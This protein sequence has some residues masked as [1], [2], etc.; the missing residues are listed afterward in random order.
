MSSFSGVCTFP[1]FWQHALHNLKE[2]SRS[3][4]FILDINAMNFVTI[5][6]NLPEQISKDIHAYK[7]AF[8]Y[9]QNNLWV[10]ATVPW[11]MKQSDLDELEASRARLQ[12]QTTA[13]DNWETSSSAG[14]QV[15]QE[16]G[17]DRIK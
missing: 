5:I 17:E 6:I 8:I 9:G 15:E 1:K 10:K 14:N 4:T 3:H 11:L 13:G 16:E 7:V 2:S 12:L